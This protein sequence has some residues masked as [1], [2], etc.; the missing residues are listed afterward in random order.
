MDSAKSDGYHW[1]CWWVGP[2]PLPP[3][4]VLPRAVGREFLDQL[5]VVLNNE[6]RAG[7]HRLSTTE[8]VSV[9]QVQIQQHD[10]HVALGVLLLVDGE[11]ELAIGDGLNGVAGQV[12]GADH[13]VATDSFR[14]RLC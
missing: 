10:G 13:H 3:T 5:C 7:V 4:Q 11:R 14:R 6:A 9:E 2:K 8:L 12:D 1:T